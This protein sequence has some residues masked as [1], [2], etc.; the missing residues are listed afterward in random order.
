MAKPTSVGRLL[1]VPLDQLYVSPRNVRANDTSDVSELAALLRSQKQIQNLSVVKDPDGKR[2]GVVAGQRRFRAF[3][4]LEQRG[5]VAPNHPVACTEVDEVEATAISIAENAGRKDMSPDEEFVAFKTLAEGGKPVED[6]AAEFGVAPVVVKRRLALAKVSPKLLDIYQS[7]GMTLEHLQAFTLV[8]SH[9]L[10]EKVWNDLPSYHRFP[11][12]IRSVL[13]KGKSDASADRLAQFVG[14]DAYEAAGGTVVRDLFGGQNSG[15]IGDVA[16]MHKLA[17]EKFDAL[18]EQ[19]RGEGWA[20]VTVIPEL[21]WSD[22]NRYGR[23]KPKTRELT[24]EEKAEIAQLEQAAADA[25]A[26]LEADGEHEDPQLTDGEIEELEQCSAVATARA[27]EIRAACSIFSDRQKKGSG[28]VLGL[29]HQG[30]LEIHRGMIEPVDP[31][32]AKAK[33]KEKELEKKKAAAAAAGE[34]EPVG[35][36]ESL[37]RKL[38]ANRT[39]ALAAHLLEAPRVA[40]DLLCARLVTEVF[41]EG[42]Y[43]NG[44]VTISAHD[45]RVHLASA[46]DDVDASKA[47]STIAEHE[48]TWR[49]Q[50]PEKPDGLFAWLSEQDVMT[51]TELLAFCTA[52]TLNAMT[53]QESVRPLSYLEETLGLN[54]ADWWQ[55]TRATFLNQVP[56][57]VIMGALDDVGLDS[58]ARS[59]ADKLKKAELA[60]YAEGVLADSGWLPGPL[61]GKQYRPLTEPRAAA[62]AESTPAAAKP[63]ATRTARAPAKSKSPAEQF[64]EPNPAAAWPFPRS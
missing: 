49:D 21:G 63:K 60:A 58:A 59:R 15:F 14:L 47:W 24:A 51:V 42:Y 30:V 53:G 4:L 41:Y 56:K 33:E 27:N 19:L 16:L 22:T 10:Q 17:A 38:T 20:F 35:Y 55:P 5:D 54:M 1:L 13:M 7:G 46:A 50:L 64:N 12:Q 6:I 23:S 25:D 34:P 52:L 62:P 3:K 57:T 2:F 61:R 36:S 48:R 8:D 43:G 11:N 44:G 37:L 32:V 26:K 28:V 9:K 29:N 18:A 40:L 31:K 39:A 45:Q